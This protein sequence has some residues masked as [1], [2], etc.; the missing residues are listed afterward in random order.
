M[1]VSYIP[2]AKAR[3]FTTHW[4]NTIVKVIKNLPGRKEY[5]LADRVLKRVKLNPVTISNNFAK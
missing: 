5:F 2:I 3:G 1:E 4:I